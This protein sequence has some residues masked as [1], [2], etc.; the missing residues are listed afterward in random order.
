MVQQRLAIAERAASAY[1]ANPHVDAVLV[2]GSV[3]RGLAD[4]YSDIELDVY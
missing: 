3:A 4:D 1:V 2:A